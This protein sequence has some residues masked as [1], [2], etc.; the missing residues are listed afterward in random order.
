MLTIQSDPTIVLDSGVS[1]IV[2]A[3][4][5]HPDGK[6]LFGGGDDGIRRWRLSDG[7]EVG[8]QTEM[9]LRAICG[10]RNGASV[11]DGDLDE[12]P[13]TVEGGNRV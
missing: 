3:V 10:T 1:E 12:K 6:H 5:F 13:I 4:A 9:R 2:Y 7:R 11:W 8:K